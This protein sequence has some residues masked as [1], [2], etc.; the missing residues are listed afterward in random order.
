MGIKKGGPMD[1]LMDQTKLG[2]KR[3]ADQP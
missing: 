3:D 2:S 1:R